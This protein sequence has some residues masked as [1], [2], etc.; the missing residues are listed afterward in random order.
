MMPE[1]ER[2]EKIGLKIDAV[3]KADCERR[4]SLFI[5]VVVGLPVFFLAPNALGELVGAVIILVGLAYAL[6]YG[7]AAS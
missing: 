4:K 5:V 3:E 1:Q 2:L 6:E 7:N